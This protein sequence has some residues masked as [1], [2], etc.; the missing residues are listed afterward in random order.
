MKKILSSS[1][2]CQWPVIFLTPLICTHDEYLHRFTRE[3]ILHV[4]KKIVI[5]RQNNVVLVQIGGWSEIH[6]AD[7]AA[8][9]RVSSDDDQ[10]VLPPVGGVV[11]PMC[12][13]ADVVA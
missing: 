6:L 1:G 10:Q 9:A 5:P 4:L 8:G 3:L 2:P 12:P 7:L 11:R 13:Y